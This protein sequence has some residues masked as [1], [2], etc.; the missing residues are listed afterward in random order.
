MQG[1]FYVISGPSGVGKSTVIGALRA[2][3]PALAFSISATTRPM[4]EGDAEGVTYYFK[5]REQ[6]DAMMQNGELLEHAEYVGNCYGTPR[7]PIEAQTAQGKNVITD[8]DVVGALQIK[9]AWPETPLIF[10][11]PPSFEVLRQ[12]LTGRGDTAPEVVEKRLAQARW[13]LSQAGKYDYIVVNDKVEN[14]VAELEAILLAE[15]CRTFCRLDCLK[16]E[17]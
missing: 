15:Q 9:Q 17:G 16:E 4:R 10:I 14:A 1:R 13:E 8:V 12:R 11:A 3:N 6:F 2:K 5:T 7:A